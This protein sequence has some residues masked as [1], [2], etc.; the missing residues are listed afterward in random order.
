[1]KIKCNELKISDSVMFLGQKEE[2]YKYYQI[3]DCLIFP[4]L[5]EG[6]GLVAIE[7]QCSGLKCICSKNVPKEVD[8]TGNVEFLSL[9]DDKSFWVNK[10]FEI[11]K[12]NKRIDCSSLVSQNG[13][14]IVVEAEILVSYYFDLLKEKI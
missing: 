7:A 9:E 2:A 14:D 1:M 13:Y 12:E 8:I 5:Y 6:L 4:S 10:I 3:F 11:V